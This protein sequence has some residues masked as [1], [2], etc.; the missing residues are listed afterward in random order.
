MQRPEIYG[1]LLNT[2][3]F[4]FPNKDN[5]YDPRPSLYSCC[6]TVSEDTGQVILCFITAVDLNHHHT[7]WIKRQIHP[8]KRL[9]SAAVY[10]TIPN[11]F[12]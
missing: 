2:K 3:C 7:H 8:P 9:C 6:C 12:S 10:F 4:S 11:W 5:I 1:L